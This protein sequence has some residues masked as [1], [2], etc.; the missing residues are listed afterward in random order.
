MGNIIRVHIYLSFLVEYM[1]HV[2]MAC[3]RAGYGADRRCSVKC[4]LEA[5]N[6]KFSG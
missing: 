6:S 3:V 5:Q 2:A 1:V 4:S